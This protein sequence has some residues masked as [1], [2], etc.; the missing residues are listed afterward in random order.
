MI[1][2]I[3]VS[4]SVLGG[5]TAK[6]LPDVDRPH[7]WLL[8]LDDAPQSYV[9]LDDPTHLEFEYARRIA[10]VLDTLPGRAP[11]APLEVLHLGGGALTLPRYT[12][13]TRPGSR[14][15][16]AE[17]DG[18]LV[19]LVTEHLPLPDGSRTVVERRDARA[20]LDEWT[21]ESADVVVADAFGGARVPVHLAT[22]SYAR[23]AARAL[24]PHGVYVANI[25]DS[26]PFPFLGPQIAT[27]A[28]VFPYL[29]LIAE[30]SVLGGRRFG[31]TVL[32]TARQPLPL[33][34]LTRRCAA[35]PFPA[36]VREG[37]QLRRIAG[38]SAP[39]GDPSE[40]CQPQPPEGAFRVG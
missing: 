5:S 26:A 27:F 16:V 18:A 38:D 29:C 36:R 1:E 31:N 24:T 32:A 2:P 23:A 7:A 21:P 19:D 37:D 33:G 13:V 25:A 4:R 35:D 9:D 3:P 30:P 14:Q 20:V 15:R 17:Y 8:T 10:H 40:V 22:L 6:L 12:T 34:E 39:V 28:E 11:P